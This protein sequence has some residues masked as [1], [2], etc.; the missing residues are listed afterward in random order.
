MGFR[1][2]FV[3]PDLTAHLIASQQ[4]PSFPAAVS[5]LVAPS[6]VGGSLGSELLPSSGSPPADQPQVLTNA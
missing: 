2:G 3:D 5:G 4:A 6:P 1:R